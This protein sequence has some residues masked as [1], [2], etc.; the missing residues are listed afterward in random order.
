MTIK[1]ILEG[2]TPKQLE[3][4]RSNWLRCASQISHEPGPQPENFIVLILRAGKVSDKLRVLMLLRRCYHLIIPV[5]T[6]DGIPVSLD[7]V[8]SKFES[9]LSKLHEQIPLPTKPCPRCGARRTRLFRQFGL[10]GGPDAEWAM[11]A[12][13][14]YAELKHSC[15]W[16]GPRNRICDACGATWLARSRADE[17]RI[18][19]YART[20]IAN[21]TPSMRH[22]E[23]VDFSEMEPIGKCPQCGDKVYELEAAYVCCRTVGAD[24]S[25]RFRAGKTILQQAISTNDMRQLLTEGRTRFLKG[26][27]SNRTKRRFTASLAVSPEG[28][29]G[30]EFNERTKA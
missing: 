22:L 3:R 9:T 26:F 15:L 13:L 20:R 6:A 2:L 27:I 4:L 24:L 12:D 23:H 5:V 25:C 17:E 7:E 28:K 1:N 19:T 18:L 21:G 10:G 16:F 11:V 29:M 14:G 8:T 30:F